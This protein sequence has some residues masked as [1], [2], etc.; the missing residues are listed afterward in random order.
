MERTVCDDRLS[1]I[2]TLW[3][4]L[5]RAHTPADGARAAQHALLER[6]GGAAY[7]YLLGSV[8][9][10]DV[11]AE[12]TQEFAVRLLRG[13]FHK[14][15]PGR[16]RFRNYLKSALSHL[17]HDHERARR[18]APGRIPAH[19]PAP[20]EAELDDDAAFLTVWRTELLDRTWDAL[21]EIR[22]TYR[23]ILLLHVD[24]PDLSSPQMAEML[25]ARRGKAVSAA[26]VRKALQRAHDKYAELLVAE[27]ARSL[28][29]PTPAQVEE[30]L[31]ALDL[32][33]YCRGA[34]RKR[35]ET[36]QRV[37]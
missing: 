16:G 25:S 15:D 9:D 2:S 10:A 30:E 1:Q 28:G 5:L 26:G 18:A 6:Y 21:A 27:V 37:R 13:D 35:A 7:R 17:V 4:M 34:L 20:A 11:A 36:D 22:P 19:P 24:Q 14:A 3:T 33:R 8:R 31:K 29:D 12:L 23:E 32:L